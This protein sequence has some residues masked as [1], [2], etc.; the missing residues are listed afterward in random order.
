MP[1]SR[2]NAITRWKEIWTILASVECPDSQDYRQGLL[3]EA[4]QIKEMLEN[5][6]FDAIDL[7]ESPGKPFEVI[8]G[9]VT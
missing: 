4:N 5:P 6:G 3:S 8:T 7:E 2:E 1:T 9:G